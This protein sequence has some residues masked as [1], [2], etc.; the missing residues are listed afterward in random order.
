MKLSTFIKAYKIALSNIYSKVSDWKGAYLHTI[1]FPGTNDIPMHRLVFIF[2]NSSIAE[3]GAICMSASINI[4]SVENIE[5]GLEKILLNK[6]IINSSTDI[7][8]VGRVLV[9]L[10]S[11]LEQVKNVFPESWKDIKLNDSYFDLDRKVMVFNID[12]FSDPIYSDGR[13]TLLGS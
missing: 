12:S 8:D 10:D 9:I 11:V 6:D 2:S 5:G 4:D 1:C 3:P 7:N 13:L